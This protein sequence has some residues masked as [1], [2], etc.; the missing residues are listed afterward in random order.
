[1]KT[2]SASYKTPTDTHRHCRFINALQCKI[3]VSKNHHNTTKCSMQM[4]PKYWSHL[5][6]GDNVIGVKPIR[7]RLLALCAQPS[8]IILRMIFGWMRIQYNVKFQPGSS[9]VQGVHLQ[10]SSWRTKSFVG[11]KAAT[12]WC[13]CGWC[14]TLQNIVQSY[15][16]VNG[17]IRV[18]RT[19]L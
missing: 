6:I 18:C 11:Q 1:M 3:L 12:P 9:K 5:N 16:G 19:G 10:Q 17:Y 4:C 15:Q 14:W 13:V 2:G 7:P 8:I